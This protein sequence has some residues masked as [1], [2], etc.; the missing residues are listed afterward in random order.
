LDSSAA[1]LV[2]AAGFASAAGFFSASGF[3]SGTLASAYG[4]VSFG[5]TSGVLVSSGF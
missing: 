4:L 1:G 3:Y 5:F 2:S